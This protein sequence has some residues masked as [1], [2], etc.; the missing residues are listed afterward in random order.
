MLSEL[1]LPAFAAFWFG[2]A[3]I[4]VGILFGFSP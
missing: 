4:M 1:I 3:A 2:I